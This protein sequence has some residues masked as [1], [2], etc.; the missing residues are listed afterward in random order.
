M[1]RVPS[2]RSAGTTAGF[3]AG[4]GQA[5]AQ[6]STGGGRSGRGKLP[7]RRRFQSLKGTPAPTALEFENAFFYTMREWQVRMLE[8]P[9]LIHIRRVETCKSCKFKGHRCSSRVCPNFSKW[10][11]T[12]AKKRA[13]AARAAS[14][15]AAEF[16]KDGKRR[17]TL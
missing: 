14:K 11:A 9:H 15:A 1:R 7:S 10:A 8:F 4:C 6:T 16:A 2:T 5:L 17:R 3:C 12:L 13:D